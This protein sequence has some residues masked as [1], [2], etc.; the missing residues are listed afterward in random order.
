M[1]KSMATLLALI[2]FI[3][4]TCFVP[5]AAAPEGTDGTPVEAMGDGG[6]FDYLQSY[7]D[8]VQPQAAADL[9]AGAVN[10][11]KA[12]MAGL[13]SIYIKEGTAAEFRTNIQQEG[14]Y[15]LKMK[16]C[17]GEGSSQVQLSL[18]LDGGIPFA[19]CKSISLRRVY[20]DDGPVEVDNR[21]NEM[22]PFQVEAKEWQTVFLTGSDNY[23]AEY[24]LFF[25]TPGQ[26][27][28]ALNAE[29]G[30]LHIAELEWCNEPELPGYDEYIKQM[31]AK[32]AEDIKGYVQMYEAEATDLKSSTGLAAGYDKQNPAVSPNDP[33]KIRI[34]M[35][36]GYNFS[37]PRQWVSWKV[38]VPESGFYQLHFK[39]RQNDLVGMPSRRKVYINGEIAFAELEETKFNYHSDWAISDLSGYKLYLEQGEDIEIKLEVTLGDMRPSLLQI[40]GALKKLDDMYRRILMITGATPDPYN[41][42]YLHKQIP[43]LLDTLKS[44]ANE[45]ENAGKA[46]EAQ[47]GKRGSSAAMV[48]DAARQIRSFIKKPNE[49][50]LRLG[51]YETTISSL[52]ATLLD[53]RNQPLALDCFAITGV[54]EKPEMR[55]KASFFEGI[56]YRVRSFFASF[57]SDY[58]TLGDS[59]DSDK[60]PLNVWLSVNDVLIT[61]VSS[62]R[63]QAM[64]LKRFVDDSFTKQWGIPVNLNL[65]NSSD[66]LMMAV[67]GGKAPDC[68][69]LVPKIIPINIAIRGGLVDLSKTAYYDTWK[70]RVNA[71]SF[72]PYTYGGGVFAMPEIQI[73]NA[74]FCRDDI[75]GDLSIEVPKTWDEFYAAAERINTVNLEVGV[76]ADVNSYMMFMMQSG[77][78]VYND[79]FSAVRLSSRGS[80]EAFTKWASLYTLRGMPQAYDF[81]DRFRTGRMPM[82]IAQ[83]TSYNHVA[84]GAPE[85]AN[86]WSI[87]PIPGTPQ[88][89]GSLNTAQACITT[90]AV[91]MK[92]TDRQDEA[93]QFVD[94]WTSDEIQQRFGRAVEDSMGASAKYY[95]ANIEAG[96]QMIWNANE[97]QTVD[98]LKASVSDVPQTPASYY[99]DRTINNAFR[100]IV[101]YNA[102]PFETLERYN[103]EI[104]DELTRKRE[105]FGLN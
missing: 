42:Y 24:Y 6:F 101:Y 1:K 25:L 46:L 99:L 59:Y 19:D 23:T 60:R 85:L 97:R 13:D 48:H 51:T 96:N 63:D 21:G 75:L 56:S 62:G 91:V 17:A 45:L 78:S 65:V 5:A 79:D 87:H 28:L 37:A 105:E 73:F 53:L 57:S 41:D 31:E 76:P 22:E 4:G 64:K 38:S 82:A 70:N 72:I 50:P 77:E 7:K 102:D 12:Q 83:L 10:P 100:R 15:C 69:I 43:D 52:S 61:G 3:T 39:Y 36:G 93:L 86:L 84:A 104:N 68:A 20:R 54:G 94:W 47:S 26:H 14:L 98:T 18:S 32:G 40:R 92:S 35:L 29:M 27:S 81:F 16:Y 90:A 11:V 9:I 67:V 71:S 33:V 2:L 58:S 95:T 88:P 89:D 34:N 66:S 103:G 49:L 44:A 55:V 74:L 30:G 8:A 80:V